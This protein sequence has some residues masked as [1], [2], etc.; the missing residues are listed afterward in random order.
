MKGRKILAW[1]LAMAMV[2]T[3][4]PV[5]VFAE[6]ASTFKA[7]QLGTD[8]IK[9]PSPTTDADGTSYYT[10]ESYIYFGVNS[11]NDSAP[12][13]WRVLDADADNSGEEGSMF[14]L[15]EN[16]LASGVQFSTTGSN[17]YSS[18]NAKSWC[19]A[20]RSPYDADNFSETEEDAMADC[21]KEDTAKTLYDTAWGTSSVPYEEMF[22]LSAEELAGYVANYNSG[23]GLIATDASGTAQDWWLRSPDAGETAKAGYVSETGLVTTEAVAK[24]KAARPAMNLDTSK[25][26]FISAAEDGKSAEGMDSGLTAVSGYDGNEWKLTILDEDRGFMIGSVLQNGDGAYTFSYEGAKTG[27]NEYISAVIVDTEA[28]EITHYGRILQLNG[29]ENADSGQV[30]LTL[31]TGVSLSK[32]T[33]L[34]VFNEQYNGDQKT[35]IASAFKQVKVSDHKNHCVCGAEHKSIGDHTTEQS[36]EWTEW[37]DALAKSQN[38]SEYTASNSLPAKS[39]NYYLTGNVTTEDVWE[40]S[41]TDI[42]LCLNG[43]SITSEDTYAIVLL[44]TDFTLTDCNGSGE[45][46]GRITTTVKDAA[47]GATGWGVQV[48]A[49]TFNMY[50]GEITGNN[51]TMEYNRDICGGGVY[52]T[53]G[54]G[55]SSFF[56][57]YGGKITE[58]K[59]K[60]TGSGNAYGGGVYVQICT[61]FNMYG[62]EISGN[63]AEAASGDAYGGGVYVDELFYA[64]KNEGEKVDAAYAEPYW[65]SFNLYGG[66]ITGNTVR[67]AAGAACGGGVYADNG[68]KFTVSGAVR[69]TGNT[70]GEAANNVQL[71][72]GGT[73]YNV[74]IMVPFYYE[75]D[76]EKIKDYKTETLDVKTYSAD[77]ITIGEALSN[78]ARIGISAA[79]EEGEGV[80]FATGATNSN[81]DYTTIFTS[82]KGD[83]ISRN[84]TDNTLELA[85]KVEGQEEYCVCGNKKCTKTT[86]GHGKVTWLPWKETNSLPTEGYY[87]LMDNVTLNDTHTI[88]DS[89]VL[90]LSLNGKNITRTN[91]TVILVGFGTSLTITD[92]E[93]SGV[94]KATGAYR[95]SV[96]NGG[97]FTLWN[98]TITSSNYSGVYNVGTFTMNGGRITGCGS[99]GVYNAGTFKMT[100]GTISGNINTDAYTNGGG[101]YNAPSASSDS[102][103]EFIMSGGSITGNSAKQGGGVYNSSATSG[104]FAKFTMSGGSITGN[105]A[106]EDG[107]GVYGTGELTVSG[108]PVISGNVKG[109]AKDDS[110]IYTDGTANNVYLPNYYTI[111]VASAGMQS[112]AQVCITG[113]ADQ[114]VV[115]DT[116]STT[117]FFSDNADYELE[118]VDVNSLK[119]VEKT[120][121]AQI[122]DV[123]Y[124][125]LSDA[126]K[127]ASGNSTADV[128]EII[129]ST[130][131]L[132]E[133]TN[134]LKAGDTIKT[135]GYINNMDERV[136]ISE[137]EAVTDANLGIYTD[138]EGKESDIKFISGK[139]Q[140]KQSVALFGGRVIATGKSG[141]EIINMSEGSDDN[142][143]MAVAPNENVT[144]N[145]DLVQIPSGG[146]AKIGATEYENA[147]ADSGDETGTPLIVGVTKDDKNTVTVELMYGAVKLDKSE[148]ITVGGKKIKNNSTDTITVTKDNNYGDMIVVPAKGNVTIGD[149]TYV[150]G[151][152]DV[153]FRLHEIS[154]KTMVT[155]M[156]GTVQLSEGS[157]IIV[158]LDEIKNSG[159]TAITV[160]V[161]VNGED[162]L[163][164]GKVTIPGGGKATID[165]TDDTADGTE[166]EAGANGATLKINDNYSI[167]LAKGSLKL[168]GGDSITGASGYAVTNPTESKSDAINVAADSENRKDAVTVPENGSVTIGSATISNVKQETVFTVE[169]SA[170]TVTLTN[171]QAVTVKG[172]AYTGGTNGGTLTID[173]ADGNVT[174][175]GDIVITIDPNALDERFSYTLA[176]GNS[177][178]IGTYTYTANGGTVTI[179]GRG[180]GRT[181]AIV[182]NSANGTVEVALSVD[183]NTKTT[184]TAVNANTMFA[185]NAYDTNTKSI[186][187]LGNGNTSANSKIEIPSGVTVGSMSDAITSAAQPTVIS[188]DSDSN[189][190]L[191]KGAAS[192]TGTMYAVINDI[193]RKFGTAAGN[194]V[195]YSVNATYNVLSLN[196][197][198]TVT[199]YTNGDENGPQFTGAAFTFE[200][201]ADDGTITGYLAGG[202]SVIG[203]NGENKSSTIT[204]VNNENTKVKI[205]KDGSV[206][207]IGGKGQSNGVMNAVMGEDH[208]AFTFESNNNKYT[209]DTGITRT[210][211]KDGVLT[212]NEE[213]AV[214]VDKMA[215]FG[216]EANA[217]FTLSKSGSVITAIIS[218]GAIVR[219][220]YNDTIEGVAAGDGKETRVEIGKDYRLT[221]LEGKGIAGGPETVNAKLAD[222]TVAVTVAEGVYATIDLDN[223][224]PAVKDLSNGESVT[225]GGVTYTAV[226]DSV[227]PLDGSKLTKTGEKAVVST[228]EEH[229][230]VQIGEDTED[231]KAPVVIVLCGNTGSVTI[232]KTENGGKVT[233]ANEGD[234]FMVGS[235]TYTADSDGAEFAVDKDGKVTRTLTSGLVTLGDGD[236]VAIASGNLIENPKDSGNDTITVKA[237]SGKDTVTVP[238]NGGKVVINNVEYVTDKDSTELE[239][240]KDGNVTLTG[241]AAVLDNNKEITVGNKTIKNISDV[242]VTVKANDP[243]AGKNSVVVAAGGKA[244]IDDAEYA[245]GSEAA[246][247]VIDE[248]GNVTLESGEAALADGKSTTGVTG[249]AITNPKDTGN[250]TIT[251]KA[252]AKNGKDTVTVAEGKGNT[253]TIGDVTYTNGSDE[254]AMVIEVTESGSKLTDGAVTLDK[255]EVIN[256]G[257]KNVAVT[258]TGDKQIE[259]ASDG[260]VTVPAGGQINLGGAEI[261]D[262]KQDTTF[263]IGEDGY[264]IIELAEGASITINGAVYVGGEDGGKITIDPIEKNEVTGVEGINITVDEDR[265][266]KDFNYVILPGQSVTIG[267]YVYTAPKDGIWGDVTIRGRGADENGKFFT[268][269]VVIKNANGTVDVAL[270]ENPETTTTYTAENANTWFAMSAD[271]TDTTKVELLDN[272]ADAKS[273]LK[274]T[275]TKS[276]VV[277]GVTYQAQTVKD[278]E[279]GEVKAVAYTVTY[280]EKTETVTNPD[281]SEE[282]TTV[283]SNTVSVDA[284][285]KII[286]TMNTGNSI[287]VNDKS[288]TATNNGASIIIDS[289]DSEN[290]NAITGN[291]SNLTEI[292]DEDGNVT[293]YEA[294]RRSSGGGSSSSASSYTVKFDTNGGSELKNISVK[295]GQAIG[296]IA[297]PTKNG[298]VFDGWYS[299]KELTKKY[300]DETKVTASTTLYAGW[301]VDPVRQLVLTIG[302][303]DATVFGQTKSNDVAPKIV[304]DRTML[305]ARF[306]AENLGAKVEW[307][308]EKQLVTI[309]GK[310]LQTGK[311]V[312]MLITIGGEYAVVN[313][314]N[315]KL[316]SPAFV[317]N[318]R[319]YTPVRFIS[320]QLGADVEWDEATQQVII[321]KALA[322]EEK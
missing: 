129:S 33:K 116:N 296:T 232:E 37:T 28:N 83:T 312:T 27:D 259:V 2:L 299:D 3:M 239:V 286:V 178:T 96:E 117:G 8:G 167:T 45:G 201:T 36:V 189:A 304:N 321:T 246:T 200:S 218:D 157:D 174:Y 67:S 211:A 169:S 20:F 203:S 12:I 251:V 80:S 91:D 224:P 292:K 41:D 82:D 199:D 123:Q 73:K 135:Y 154:D 25:I 132:A 190:R 237:D 72:P 295:N 238:Q 225:Y 136:S 198:V 40:Q 273:A 298:Y 173:P 179:R 124:T 104:G 193:T 53:N 4:F 105:N 252:D 249:K 266:T 42:V 165:N 241:G 81:L 279:T 155:F 311:D 306:V 177:I 11:A 139:I 275:D 90:Y 220:G 212:L 280:G 74:A 242:T 258:N 210:Q 71:Y 302:N 236:A 318:D 7:I 151:D 103:A 13:K 164:E 317:E 307:N 137:I 290:A 115:T 254:N 150:V 127:A 202:A 257:D 274:F 293:G 182:L 244:E 145:T 213:G 319:T 176:D 107:G 322:S 228:D 206:C 131:T 282:I 158:G 17:K 191:E 146:K 144:T 149:S 320:E 301:K 229:V 133:G 284:G 77:T 188:L 253:V 46:N 110:G 84:S 92:C 29:T 100:E 310:N 50:G 184:Y 152:S 16:V 49:A 223:V 316:D 35:D 85:A 300:D 58:N 309:T 222:K 141:V 170:V 68:A 111:R 204:G 86:D 289:T 305:P 250:D 79:L 120:S 233:V 297:A 216:G 51:I 227:F 60:N 75:D 39:G 6:N 209:V 148:E 221:L 121:E 181:P 262:V 26:H 76:P 31:P 88:S 43:Y 308:G 63:T 160:E 186:D 94:I 106:T 140:V 55:T 278:A 138:P 93:G 303:K 147:S 197:N 113:A 56:N 215:I 102:H 185:M 112:G 142:D 99:C 70:A 187:L 230:N 47:T 44:L 38:G 267:K 208:T 109:G 248:E 175:K 156:E 247:F 134:T 313:G 61:D 159:D 108:A 294:R 153:T 122:G 161:S 269:A 162:Y 57:M 234:Q 281:G 34:Y 217:E 205:G 260:K 261:T 30:T 95:S 271:D 65:M 270:S 69:I 48:M 168:G 9:D 166:Y 277:N 118:L 214:T 21:D 272:G 265:L 22:F 172:M 128:I 101:V 59:V 243:E 207:L 235:K 52:L 64:L 1:L 180:V 195:S 114:T 264:A 231:S 143:V 315:I 285:S 66:K 87:Y 14:L 23:S 291:R 171:G 19:S 119:L 314:E 192:T 283:N 288:V 125:T 226:D 276:H 10:P 196:S 194:T 255:D 15:S 163:A 32:T 183:R 245:A 24:E 54:E 5:S 287:Q 78:D 18:S 240:D 263:A 97:T 126:L 98:G 62:G 130:V 219:N 268:P 256:V 89:K